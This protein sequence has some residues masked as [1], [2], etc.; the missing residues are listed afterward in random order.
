MRDTDRAANAAAQFLP[1]DPARP[2]DLPAVRIGGA[3][4]FAYV[5]EGTLCISADLDEMTPGVFRLYAGKVPVQ[6]AV[7]GD[8]VYEA[9]AMWPPPGSVSA[10]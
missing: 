9:A 4:V 2:D 3:L 7:Q 10:G 1:A 8:V 5:C 6:V